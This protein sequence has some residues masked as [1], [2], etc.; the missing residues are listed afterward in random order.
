MAY[1][2]GCALLERSRVAPALSQSTTKHS[3]AQ[4]KA[5]TMRNN[6]GYSALASRPYERQSA[7]GATTHHGSQCF[8]L[9]WCG[10]ELEWV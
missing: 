1:R 10:L 9:I 3:R 6:P 5:S 7:T 8:G 2:W 4:Q